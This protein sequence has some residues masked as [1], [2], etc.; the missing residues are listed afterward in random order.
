MCCDA[1]VSR[2]VTA[3]PCQILD[4]GRE[5][6][7]WTA[8]QRRAI[9]ARDRSCRGC[10]RPIGWTEIHH[11]RWWRNGGRTDLDNGIALCHHCHRLI[12]DHGWHVTLDPATAAVTWT[13]PD[14]RRT[15]VTHPRPPC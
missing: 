13:S 6:R 5:T 10:A 15:R 3:G 12:H 11:I 7:E 14:R 1:N 2:I 4:V 9:H 8:S